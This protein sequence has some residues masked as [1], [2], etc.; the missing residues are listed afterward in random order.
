MW[1]ELTGAAP[2]PNAAGYR[3]VNVWATWCKPCVEELPLLTRTF[4]DWKK[5]GQQ[6]TLTLLSVDAD[7]EAAKKFI[8]DRPGTPAS[9]QLRDAAKAGDWLTEVGLASG[10]AIPVHTVLDAN[11]RLVCARPAA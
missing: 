1:P 7:A 9:L 10:A 8:A 11:G 5:Q 3:W 6:V 4:D 2:Q